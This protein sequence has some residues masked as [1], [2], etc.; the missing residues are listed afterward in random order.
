MLLFY[1]ACTQL[2]FGCYRGEVVQ[3]QAV[4]IAADYVLSR[5]AA[6]Y[7]LNCSSMYMY[8][9]T[10]RF[11]SAPQAGEPTPDLGCSYRR[12]LGGC[13]VGPDILLEKCLCSTG[14]SKAFESTFKPFLIQVLHPADQ[15]CGIVRVISEI[16]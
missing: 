6:R 14:S 10:K 16:G 9:C 2:S 4:A 7:C 13:L 8:A 12:R 15:R 5:P 1:H 3:E 11:T